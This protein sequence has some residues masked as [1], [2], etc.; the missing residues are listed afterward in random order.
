MWRAQCAWQTRGPEPWETLAESSFML[1]VV[2]CWARAFREPSPYGCPLPQGHHNV[3]TF[4]SDS[5]TEGSRSQKPDTGGT[6]R[7]F[8]HSSMVG[9]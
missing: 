1:L 6:T 3:T 9:P 5:G 7:S 8:R 4:P 2:T